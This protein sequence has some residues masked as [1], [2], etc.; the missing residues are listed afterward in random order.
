MKEIIDDVKQNITPEKIF[1]AYP[2][3]LKLQEYNYSLAIQWAI[4]CIEIYGYEFNPDK[5]SQM[6][7]YIQQIDEREILTASQCVEISREIWYLSE[8]EDL[9]TAVAQLW[10]SISFKYGDEEGK[11]RARDIAMVVELLL[12]DVSNR[13]LLDKYLSTAQRIY[14]EYFLQK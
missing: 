12:P 14:E 7:K 1:W 3:A 10:G 9:Q 5:L 13:S 4:E 11:Y 6:N 2:I 8:R